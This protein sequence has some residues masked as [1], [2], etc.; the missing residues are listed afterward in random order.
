MTPQLLRS[1]VALNLPEEQSVVFLTRPPKRWDE[2][3]DL[4]IPILMAD[5]D[6]TWSTLIADLQLSGLSGQHSVSLVE[7]SGAV[8]RVALDDPTSIRPPSTDGWV[9]ALNWSKPEERPQPERPLSSKRYLITRQKARGEELAERLRQLGAEALTV[10]TIEF[11]APDSEEAI[12]KAL[13]E[14]STFDWLIFTSPNGV[15]YF[16]EYL[17]DAG[18]DHRH[19]G[20]VKF[21]CIGPGTAAALSDK[22][23]STDLM[24][25]EYVAE[26]LLESFPQELSGQRLLLPR[27]Q[28]ARSVLPVGLEKR[29]AS[30]SV[31]PVYKTIPAPVP[32][33]DVSSV[34]YQDRLLFTSASTVKNWV[35]MTSDRSF[36]CFCIG[37]ITADTARLEGFEVLGMASDYTVDGLLDLILKTDRTTP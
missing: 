23:F 34:L 12:K 18:L 36:P 32:N 31:C 1:A 7:K 5:T 17:R 16:F 15:T 24:P 37:P 6:T 4:D 13:G 30:V 21:A 9:L 2:Y 14:L 8:H 33:F 29:G 27:A 10:P 11:C 26:S 22:G 35:K 28:V 19:L 20:G 3:L 25:P